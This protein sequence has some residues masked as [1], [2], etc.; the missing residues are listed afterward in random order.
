MQTQVFVPP[1]ETVEE[2]KLP[3]PVPDD[4]KN[5]KPS[6]SVT[7]KRKRVSK[8]PVSDLKKAC[9]TPVKNA[10]HIFQALLR[11]EAV[12]EETLRKALGESLYKM[13]VQPKNPIDA[14][15]VALV[16]G[17]DPNHNNPV[18]ALYLAIDN[19]NVEYCELLLA[20]GASVVQ[21]NKKRDVDTLPITKAL[22]KS[23]GSKI[24]KL[25]IEHVYNLEQW[26]ANSNRKNEIPEPTF[27][28]PSQLSPGE[29]EPPRKVAKLN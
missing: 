14:L 5:P 26:D 20:H 24:Y 4:I 8:S 25:F 2:E 10:R 23:P 29:S 3:L 16:E 17:A 1:S 13:V 27:A 6:T 18:T 9:N 21:K 19:D 15:R 7:G 22:Q 28:T 12:P 11:N